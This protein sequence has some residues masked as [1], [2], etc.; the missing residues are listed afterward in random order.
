M[1]LR[2]RTLHVAQAAL[3]YAVAP[4]SLS[5]LGMERLGGRLKPG[6]P[7]QLGELGNTLFGHLQVCRACVYACIGQR[8]GGAR[9]AP[10]LRHHHA[11]R[12]MHAC[13]CCVAFALRWGPPSL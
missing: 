13:A 9:D 12:C 2:T 10:H 4:G 11:M 5:T 8:G 7:V 1:Y 3:P 6:I